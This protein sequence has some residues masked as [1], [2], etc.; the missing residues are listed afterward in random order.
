M[1]RPAKGRIGAWVVVWR[2]TAGTTQR[3]H[4]KKR[5]SHL[6]LV[7][8]ARSPSDERVNLLLPLRPL[9]VVSGTR[10]RTAISQSLRSCGWLSRSSPP[11]KKHQNWDP[12]LPCTI[13]SRVTPLL[14]RSLA[15]YFPLLDPV[16]AGAAEGAPRMANHPDCLS[17]RSSRSTSS[18]LAHSDCLSS[19]SSRS[20]SSHLAAFGL[21]QTRCR[22]ILHSTLRGA[23]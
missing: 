5:K 9:D 8:T 13:S 12:P 6:H 7:E 18:H 17:V 11:P 19:R 2:C 15:L 14:S 16:I 20:S 4:C 10:G 23:K 1:G 22:V 21:R 3:S